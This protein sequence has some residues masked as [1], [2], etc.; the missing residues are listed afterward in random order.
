MSKLG[1]MLSLTSVLTFSASHGVAAEP[2]VAPMPMV[3]SYLKLNDF[4]AHYNYR[5]HLIEQALEITRPEFGDYQIKPYISQT[6]SIRYAQLLS[7]GDQLNVLWTSPGTPATKGE[8]IVIPID[9]IKG[10]LGYRVCLI[11]ADAPPKLSA[12]HTLELLRKIKVGQAQWPDRAIYQFNN[13][14]VVDTP[15]FSNLF[16]MLAAQRFDCIPLGVDEVERVYQAK[17]TQYPFLA[18]DSHVLIY[19]H[20]PLYLYVSKRHPALA[21]RLSVGLQKMQNNG[22][23]DRLFLLFHADN[24]ARLALKKRTLICLESPYNRE[25]NQCAQPPKYPGQP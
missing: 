23:F 12:I 19:Y 3:V 16:K 11:N 22:E 25:P 1:I 17:K 6:S 20:Y 21:E 13:I 7:D 24:F 4:D 2:V 9:I 14:V 18:I 5:Y 10:L 15:N 8:A